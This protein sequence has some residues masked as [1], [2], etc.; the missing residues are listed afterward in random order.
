MAIF[1]AEESGKLCLGTEKCVVQTE[2]EVAGAC[3]PINR[4]EALEGV[5]I[6]VEV[7]MQFGVF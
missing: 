4:R 3:H 1:I 7:V 6:G 2:V 5:V